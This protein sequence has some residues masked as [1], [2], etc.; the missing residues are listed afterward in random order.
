[1]SPLTE[2][3]YFMKKN[4]HRIEGLDKGIRNPMLFLEVM[5]ERLINRKQLIA[6]TVTHRRVP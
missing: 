4:K 1:M 2:W 3:P 6:F 5:N